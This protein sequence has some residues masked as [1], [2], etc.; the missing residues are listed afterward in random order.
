M[1]QEFLEQAEGEVEEELA[2]DLSAEELQQKLERLEALHEMQMHNEDKVTTIDESAD[3]EEVKKAL[4]KNPDI[5]KERSNLLQGRRH[6]YII[7]PTTK[8]T[9]ELAGCMTH[10]HVYTLSYTY[11]DGRWKWVPLCVNK[12]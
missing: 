6:T 9:S 1:V 4:E 11:T 5:S 3:S 10:V 7:Q 8:V 2:E 12:I